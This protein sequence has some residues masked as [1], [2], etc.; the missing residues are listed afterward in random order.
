MLGYEDA[1]GEIRLGGGGIENGRKL[2]GEKERFV[3]MDGR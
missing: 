3:Q 1:V 2:E